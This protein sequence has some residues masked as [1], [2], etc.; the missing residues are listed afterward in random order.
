V[1]EPFMAIV[2]ELGRLPEAGECAGAAVV[3]E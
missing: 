1:L 3:V 2:A